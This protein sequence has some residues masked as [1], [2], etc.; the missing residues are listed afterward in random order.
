VFDGTEARALSGHNGAVYG[1]AFRPDGRL[2][3]SASADRTV[4]LW[5]VTTGE[6]RDTFS[7]PLK[8]QVGVAWSPDGKRLA[9]AGADHRIRVWDVSAQGRETT[10][11]LAIAR[12]AHEQPLVRLT[13]SRDGKSLLSSAQDGTLKAWDA[14]DI[15]ERLSLPK[16]AD[17]PTAI[18]DTGAAI[19]AGLGNG[20]L[21]FFHPQT[22]ELL[23]G[24]QPGACRGDQEGEA[25]AVDMTFRASCEEDVPEQGIECQGPAK[26]EKAATKPEL[27][28]LSPPG[29]QR[30]AQADVALFGK[31]LPAL[32][33]IRAADPRVSIFTG[34]GDGDRLPFITRAPADLP[35]GSYDL[36]A[37]GAD[38]KEIGRLPLR[39][40][41]I[42]AREFAAAEV[43]GVIDLPMT[44]WGGLDKAGELDRYEFSARSGQTIVV[45]ASSKNVGGKA[46]LVVQLTDAKGAVLASSNQ[47]NGQDAPFLAHRVTADGKY[48]V[49][50]KD[51]QMTGGPDHRYTMTIGE[52]P[53]VVAAF[54]QT[55][56]ANAET[57]VELVGYNLP[58]DAAARRLKVKAGA[59][60][61]VAL[62]I[63]AQRFFSRANAQ[64]GVTDLPN[65]VEE[66]AAGERGQSVTV[67]VSMNGRIS[68]PGERDAYRFV[69]VKGRIYAIETEAARRNS[70]ADTRISV[71]SADG[72]PVPRML[73]EAVRDSAITFR[74]IDSASPDARVENWREMGLNELMWT[75]GEINKIF[76]MP[77]GPDSGFQYYANAG[78]RIAFFDTSPTA[79]ALDEPCYIV[80][81]HPPGTP[82]V[83]NGLPRFIVNYENDDDGDREI[84]T[85]SRLL[86]TAPSDGEFLVRVEESQGF[87]GDHFAYRLVIREA[88]EKF[89]VMVAEFDGT[90]N[91][92]SGAAFTLVAN[93]I[94]G[95][96]GEIRCEI[97][98]VP[99]GWHVTTPLVIEAGHL[100]A[101]GCLT[102]LPGAKQPSAEEWKGLNIVAR[103][104]IA[105]KKAEQTI[106]PFTLPKLTAAPQLYVGMVPPKIG[107]HE[108]HGGWAEFDAGKPF[109]I[110]IAP[111]EIIPAWLVVKRA[112]ANGAF[113]FEVENLPH[114]V[115]V[116]NLG[117]NGITLLE[118][119][120]QGEIFFKAAPWVKEQERL[121]FAVCR[122]AGKQASLPFVLRVKEKAEKSTIVNVK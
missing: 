26:A 16:Q 122:E 111:G 121:A 106:P 28:R 80:E 78:K 86:F 116:D 55:I 15:K 5:D 93:R 51:L 48:A 3:A 98:G 96:D 82:L 107:K 63:D 102:A 90:V 109:E 1:V 9:A 101:K 13:W 118:G 119:Q 62:P 65:A 69:A 84:G 76:R 89:S 36:L 60:G 37:I 71:L 25:V 27:T 100:R 73:F 17:W 2:L 12:Y 11:P 22:G 67:P 120:E 95:F 34:T 113:R 53:W 77:E 94:D 103:A 21:L 64:L 20:E 42:A 92:G 54:P 23:P 74:P 56:G 29:I 14:V 97:G 19:V 85:D 45:D 57:E 99:A 83:A 66:D 105:G 8:E 33:S 104:T 68:R 91:A 75:G 32:I 110:A 59:P 4:K 41:D 35:R 38:G 58:A 108:P 61:Q 112:G 87:G 81:P 6:R 10:N 88:Q 47:F 70:P 49:L 72:K 43:S 117:L 18:A 30:G 39:V 31:N 24:K 115:I 46:D 79:H 7:Q 50:V 44:L 40:F 114:G 52:L